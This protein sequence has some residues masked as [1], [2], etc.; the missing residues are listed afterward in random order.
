MKHRMK[1]RIA[2]FVSFA[3]AFVLSGAPA[4]AHDEVDFSRDVQPVLQRS[5]G[6][7]ACH[8][9][10]KT[11][12]VELTT[13]QAIIASVGEQYQA[14]IIKP[15]DPAGSPLIDKIAND[16]PLFGVREPR[17]GTPLSGLEISTIARW[18]QEGAKESH[19]LVRGDFNGDDVLDITDP[20]GTLF[21]LFQGGPQ[22][23]C[24]EVAD[25]DA[26]GIADV[27]D[28]IFV[29]DH[30]FQGGTGPEELSAEETEACLKRPELSF[31]SIYTKVFKASCAFSS[32]HSTQAHKGGLSLGTLDEAYAGL[33]G[34]QASNATA[35]AAGYLR[36]AAGRPENSFLVRKLDRPGPGEGNR[37]PPNSSVG[38]SQSAKDA[39]QQWILAGAPKDGT[40]PGVPDITDV[41]LPPI[42]RIPQPPAPEN[43][44]QLH[45]G[46]FP[47]A[48]R[49]ERE[50]FYFMGTPLTS[51]AEDLIVERIDI[52]MADDSHHF[53]LYE[54][55]GAQNPPAGYRNIGG[56]LDI[57]SSRRFI[58][59]AQQS[60]F[61]L[62]FPPGVGLKLSRLL[63]M[64][65]NSHF[66]NLHNA[67][68]LQGEV[69]MNI[70]L[71]APGTITTFAKP[72][73]DINPFINVPP[74]QTRTTKAA[75][76]QESSGRVPAGKEY[77]IYALGSH[78]HRHGVRFSGFVV[79]NLLDAVPPNMVYDNYSWDDPVFDVFETPLVLKAGQGIRYEATHTYDDPPSP[80]SPPLQFG[81]TSEDEMAILLGYYAVK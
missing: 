15:G 51:F 72:V 1:H 42:D 61:S 31:D 41:P 18:I 4:F 30:L 79:S 68:T 7:L 24:E 65:L 47:I 63:K 3:I 27:T 52:H 12:G 43:G 19:R 55:T 62:A 58:L 9:T 25:A 45:L 37:M 29:L 28:A 2:L 17:D 20:I 73:F 60:F 69:Y 5:C 66:V 71:A 21:F 49:S 53:I 26:S 40:I 78:T 36:V 44:I 13:Y 39:I 22:P 64:D 34:I 77:H 56:A 75:F 81:I 11:S 46:P 35:L 6:G 80:S 67:S 59:G 10:Q 33:V 32:C 57:I 76:P 38:L 16:A 23:L 70:F 54:W 74:N 50:I 8:L 48:P 14:P